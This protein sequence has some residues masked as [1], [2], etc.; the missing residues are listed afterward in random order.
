MLSPLKVVRHL[1]GSPI[2]LLCFKVK[3]DRY[4]VQYDVFAIRMTHH[5]SS[6]TVMEVQQLPEGLEPQ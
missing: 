1:T 4:L 5:T 3:R 2:C 6:A